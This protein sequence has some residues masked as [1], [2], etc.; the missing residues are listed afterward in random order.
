MP[1]KSIL[2]FGLG[3]LLATFIGI[4]KQKKV[5]GKANKQIATANVALS[6]MQ[7]KQNQLD[8]YKMIINNDR[9]YFQREKNR[10]QQEIFDLRG[11][12]SSQPVLECPV[13]QPRK[14]VESFPSTFQ[15]Q[16]GNN[17]YTCRLR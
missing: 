14:V 15:I 5:A 16:L 3:F 17:F 12:L 2:I 9:E 1:Y 11:L 7:E 6:S 4:Y 10:L 13:N 8:N